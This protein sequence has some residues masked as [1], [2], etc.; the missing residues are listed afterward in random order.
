MPTAPGRKSDSG[1]DLRQSWGPSAPGRLFTSSKPWSLALDGEQF[2]LTLDG[3][4]RA[5]TVLGLESL[6]VRRGAL[7][8]TI[9]LRGAND[10]VLRLDGIPNARAAQLKQLVD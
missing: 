8:A 10:Q 3:Q 7:W 9:E 1:E 2:T 4:A 5:G 6:A